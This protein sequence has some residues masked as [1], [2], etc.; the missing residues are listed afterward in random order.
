[1]TAQKRYRL[2]LID[3]EPAIYDILKTLLKDDYEIE[4]NESAEEAWES[5]VSSKK[6]FDIIIVDIVLPGVNGIEFIKEIREINP[7]IPIIV[8]TGFSTHEWAKQAANLNISGYIEKP[9]DGEKLVKAV[10]SAVGIS[11]HAI[12][13]STFQTHLLKKKKYRTFHPSVNICLEKIRSNVHIP[14]N[15]D[16][17]SHTVGIS[18]SHLCKLFK[19]DCGM[20]INDYI[21]KLRIELAKEFLKNSPYSISKIQ[22]SVGYKSRTHFYYTFKRLT[23]MSPMEFRKDSNNK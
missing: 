10:K 3:D 20:T 21:R 23:G 9:F 2:L 4:Y 7:C 1:M 15:I 13:N 17:L 6:L 5:F 14:L 12:L 16:D 11:N 19:E 8:I 18:K 22:E